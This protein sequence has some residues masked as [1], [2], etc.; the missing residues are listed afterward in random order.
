MD[1]AL[2][3]KKGRHAI[4]IEWN[5]PEHSPFTKMSLAPRSSLKTHGAVDEYRRPMPQ[6][7]QGGPAL[8]LVAVVEESVAK[9]LIDRW[10]RT[11]VAVGQHRLQ[12]LEFLG[13]LMSGPQPLSADDGPKHDSPKVSKLGESIR[14]QFAISARVSFAA[15]R[16]ADLAYDLWPVSPHAHA[17]PLIPTRANRANEAHA[18]RSPSQLSDQGISS[19]SCVRASL[20]A[21]KLLRLLL[22]D[23]SAYASG[24][25]IRGGAGKRKLSVR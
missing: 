4:H 15:S 18:S 23:P 3:N 9:S 24:A 19:R 16:N 21:M 7:F 17:F 8:L 12:T 5:S 1:G 11:G 13:K 25:D 14:I 22:L 6:E 20:G 2:Q 10:Q